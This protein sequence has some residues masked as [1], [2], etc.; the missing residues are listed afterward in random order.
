[1]SL[2]AGAAPDRVPSSARFSWIDVAPALFLMVLPIAH[3]TPLRIACLVLSALAAALATRRRA[4]AG[5]PTTSLAVAIAFWS[6]VCLAACFTSI[7][8]SYSW[9]ELRNEVLSTVAAFVVF[10]VLTDDA[11]ATRRW[12][13]ALLVSFIVIAPFA[14][15]SYL[16]GG[17]W[18]RGGLTGDRNAYS[19]YIVLIVPFLFHRWFTAGGRTRRW[20]IGIAAA[21][22]LA[23]V[24]GSLTQNRNLWFAVAVEGCC[25]AALVWFRQSP[26]VRRRLRLR[27]LASAVVGVVV[28]A[29]ALAF[30]VHQKAVVSR[31]STAEQARFDRDPRFEIWRYAGERISEHPWFGH[32]YGRGI[33]RSDFRT[34]FANPLKWHGHNLVVNYALEAG[35]VGVI[36]IVGLLLALIVNAWRV[37]R[38]GDPSLWPLG[39]WALTM[40]AG[41]LVKT[42]TDD[43]LVRD[44][45][46]LFWSVLGIVFGQASRGRRT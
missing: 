35:V 25:F 46:L 5:R 34:H 2:V 21:I 1:M 42:M 3:T 37:Y 6:C 29:G 8:P 32:G 12:S 41:L 16:L 10:W 40:I 33:L 26:E 27:Y 36:A 45:A 44:N 30:V 20:R 19:T 18:S 7:E 38:S 28:F 14:T 23:L 17:D 15:A 31:T 9:G 43:I 39:A 11:S 4:S 24:S 22:V 13:I